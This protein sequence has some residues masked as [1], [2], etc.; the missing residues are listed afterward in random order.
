MALDNNIISQLDKLGIA[1]TTPTPTKSK[2]L[3]QEQFLELMIAQLKNQDPFK[4]ME[5]GEFIT[6]IA[7]FSSV[8][9]IKT[10]QESFAGFASSMQSNLALQASSMVGR[11]VA[12][13][14]SAAL[15]R[16]SGLNGSAELPGSAERVVI[17]VY[18]QAGELIK[19][20]D[21][22]AQPAGMI[23]FNWDGLD[24][25]GQRLPD[26]V[27]QIKAEAARAGQT[28]SLRTYTTAPVDSVVI[29][30]G[31]G[32]LTLNLGALGSAEFSD[33]KEIM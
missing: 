22:G 25:R 11:T 3:G 29:G 26:G 30:Q 10:L 32:K 1:T 27:Y 19:Q 33:V 31:A 23:N 12:I 17:G 24:S 20:M 15:L 28:I 13:P 9:G 21:L 5:N 7:Q 8:T 18:S 14:S 6:Q 16:Q 2:E 4:P